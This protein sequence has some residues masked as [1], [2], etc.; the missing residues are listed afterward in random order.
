MRPSDWLLIF[1]LGCLIALGCAYD[2][3]TKPRGVNRPPV[4]QIK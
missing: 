2:I 3:S 4:H 1:I